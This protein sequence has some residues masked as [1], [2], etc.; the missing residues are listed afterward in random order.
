MSWSYQDWKQDDDVFYGYITPLKSAEYDQ[1]DINEIFF[2]HKIDSQFY[3]YP[4]T[5]YGVAP[6]FDVN[7]VYHYFECND[8]FYGYP[9]ALGITFNPLGAF[10][11][12]T[13]LT[14]ITIP[15]SVYEF[16]THSFYKSGI[17][18][19]TISPDS[20]IY[21]NTFDANC[22]ISFY[23]F[24][25]S[26]PETVDLYINQTDLDADYLN[27][28]I[29]INGKVTRKLKNVYID[30]DVSEIG[31]GKT[32]YI[33]AKYTGC[34]LIQITYNV[35]PKPKLVMTITKTRVE[36][37]Y[38]QFSELYFYDENQTRIYPE[39]S[40]VSTNVTQYS[41]FEGVEKCVDNNISTK[42]LWYWQNP[43]ILEISLDSAFH[44][45]YMSYVTGN[46]GVN[47]DP[48]SF[49]IEYVDKGVSTLILSVSDADIT[50]SRTTET[51]KFA[52]SYT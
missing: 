48:V 30:A 26:S 3:G 15:E 50:T 5:V 27:L 14:S 12:C 49:T 9:A 21:D 38:G 25:V 33:V 46:D 28:D 32:G 34:R 35:I 29:T 39:I 11:G 43:T 42:W 44:P 40:S 2:S 19:I 16:G 24:T 18:S 7:K 45:A 47:W 36:Q 17:R 6:K 10:M 20:V 23:S 52:F 41:S 31:Q 51:Q 22:T 8:A 37:Q 1:F 4:H 13:S